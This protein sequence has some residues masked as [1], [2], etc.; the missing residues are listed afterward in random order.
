M[1]G[2]LLV[3]LHKHEIG[4]A[5]CAVVSHVLRYEYSHLIEFSLTQSLVDS[6]QIPIIRE[7]NIA[8]SKQCLG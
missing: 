6:E 2:L 1:S 4:Y 8:P 5:G 3:L 7:H